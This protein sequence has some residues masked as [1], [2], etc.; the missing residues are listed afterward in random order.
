MRNGVWTHSSENAKAY[1]RE[2]EHFVEPEW[3]SQRLFDEEKFEG[4]VYDPACGFGRI[5]R[6]A[7]D[8]GLE[9]YGSDL[10]SRGACTIVIRDFFKHKGR[11]HN[12]VTNPPFDRIKEFTLHALKLARRKV[13]VIMPVARLNAADW[14]MDVPLRR[15]WL[16]LRRG[17]RCRL[18]TSSRQ[19]GKPPGGKTDYC[20]LVF[21]LRLHWRSL[22]QMDASGRAQMFIV[23]YA[24]KYYGPFETADAA[25]RSSPR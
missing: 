9:A 5:V 20:W 7:Y 17:R 16:L 22:Y 1:P 13:A 21:E 3:V 6:S 23:S 4:E 15:V 14:L 24:A 8:A 19:A 18:V 10:V 11:H 2:D 25:A 12:I